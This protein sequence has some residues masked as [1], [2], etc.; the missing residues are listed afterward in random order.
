MKELINLINTRISII[1]KAIKKAEPDNITCP[2]GSLRIS[3]NG[4]QC[5]YY[6][7]SIPSD[8]TGKYI[9]KKDMPL[10]EALA[11]K[12]YNRDFLRLAKAELQNLQKIKTLLSA[13]NADHAYQNLSPCRQA[14]ITPYI[15]PDD[16]YIKEWQEK[17]YK[18]NSYME[19]NK[20]Y[21]TRKGEKVRS[22]SEAILADLFYEL[23][24]PYHYEKPLK[25]NDGSYRYPDFTLLKV[26]TREEIYLEHFGLLDNE[27]YLA[28][29]LHKLDEYRRNDIYPGKNLLFTYETL[30]NPFD[31]KG[32]RKMIKDLFV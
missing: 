12:A 21:D 16:L 15:L 25:F 7:I 32:I 24:I 4:R 11:Q 29:S 1:K 6:L 3:N 30:E 27:E 2:E 18:I 23:K 20:V 10:I 9:P 22:K 17:K 14:L 28:N 26:R 5:R 13:K 31:I 8:T 19:E